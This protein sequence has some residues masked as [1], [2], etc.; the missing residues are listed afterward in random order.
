MLQLS[1][2]RA[3]GRGPPAGAIDEAFWAI[4]VAKYNVGSRRQFPVVL[5]PPL[6]SGL[7]VVESEV[8]L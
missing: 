5:Y 4:G 7:D 8:E 1:A 6:L 3:I 2:S